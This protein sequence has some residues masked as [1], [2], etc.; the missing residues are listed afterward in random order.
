MQIVMYLH[1]SLQVCADANCDVLTRV[2]AIMCWCKSWRTYMRICKYVLMQIVM[3]L[4]ASLQAPADANV[5]YLHA[6]L[7]VR[8][9][10]NRDV[11]TRVFAS[12]CWWKSWC[13]YRRLCKHLLIQI[14]M[15]LHASLQAPAD[16]NRNVLTRVFASTCYYKYELATDNASSTYW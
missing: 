5:M 7:Q 1:A 4:Q 14:A 13:T 6:S 12:T 2:F 3:Y 8:A 15:Y 11:L 9:D 10:T 16:T